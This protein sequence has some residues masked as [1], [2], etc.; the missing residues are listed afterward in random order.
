MVEAEAQKV[1]AVVPQQMWITNGDALLFLFVIF[2][3]SLWGV[4][5]ATLGRFIHD[6]RVQRGSDRRGQK[7]KPCRSR[8]V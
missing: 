3:H 4:R 8:C 7:R 6:R 5:A 2:N 1:A